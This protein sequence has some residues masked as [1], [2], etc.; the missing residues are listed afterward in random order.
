MR[1]EHLAI[2]GSA[3]SFEM[4]ADL[5][6]SATATGWAIV[7]YLMR[8]YP[9]ATHPP[10][11]SHIVERAIRSTF[12]KVEVLSVEEFGLKG[13]TLRIG[14][15]RVPVSTGG[16]RELIVGAWEGESGCL[17]TSLTGGTREDLI[18]VFDTLQFTPGRNGISVDSPVLATPRPPQV[19]K[20]V[21]RLGVV[22]VQPAVASVLDRVP[23]ARGFATSAGELFRV[24]S[25]SRALLLVTRSTVVDIN[26]FEKQDPDQVLEA[27]GAL[28]VDWR[29]RRR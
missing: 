4:D 13:G 29:V 28:R 27:A 25:T 6:T 21:P 7:P 18:Q 16:T 8:S 1:A 3:V 24:N 11:H 22:T 10:R 9:L 2:D 17:T 14:H 20:E 19:I 5:G 26:P 12:P 23:R 15:V